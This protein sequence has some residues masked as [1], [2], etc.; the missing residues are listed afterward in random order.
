VLL[1]EKKNKFCKIS[2]VENHGY[3][4]LLKKKSLKGWGNEGDEIT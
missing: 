1:K 4:S 2:L 3:V